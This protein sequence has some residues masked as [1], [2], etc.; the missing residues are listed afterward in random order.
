M[1]NQ[2][3]VQP[4]LLQAICFTH[5]DFPCTDFQCAGCDHDLVSGRRLTGFPFQLMSRLQDNLFKGQFHQGHAAFKFV[6]ID[7]EQYKRAVDVYIDEV[8]SSTD[9]LF[10]FLF[11]IDKMVNFKYLFL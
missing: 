4:T 2:A 9:N 8:S 3:H 10:G 11:V 1:F 5:G 6:P 7:N